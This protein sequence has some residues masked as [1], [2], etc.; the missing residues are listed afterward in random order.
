[1]SVPAQV[2]RPPGISLAETDPVAAAIALLRRFRGGGREGGPR[3]PPPQR[4]DD[5]PR[6]VV[7]SR[8]QQRA[9]RSAKAAL[10]RRGGVLLADR[11][12]AGKTYLALALIE[13]ALAGGQHRILVTGPAALAPQ[14]LPLLRRAARA[15]GARA[16][17]HRSGAAGPFGR[18]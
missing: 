16:F 13:D 12:G 7:L 1:V 11:T 8:D 5:L 9:V 4:R 3:D 18:A 6:S 17:A 2:A 14:W 10:D 15:H